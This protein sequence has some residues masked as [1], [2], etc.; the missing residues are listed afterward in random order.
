MKTQCVD[1]VVGDILASWRY[2]ISGIFPEMRGDYEAHFAECEHC[3][4]K[5]RLHRTID[6][7]LIG[8]ATLSAFVF[9]VAFAV[10]HQ[11]KP[12]HAFWLEVGSLVGFSLSAFIWLLVAIAT[13][14]PIVAVEAARVGA[15]R[16]HDRLPEK[17]RD[18][19]P[20]ELWVKISGQS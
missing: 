4:A 17:I 19:I 7:T 20:E 11:L 9:L 5:R 2:D 12:Q 6:F 13:P 15:R 14:A 10:I 3:Q 18:R 8:L 1:K 16:V